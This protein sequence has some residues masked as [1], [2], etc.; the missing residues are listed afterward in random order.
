MSVAI[1]YRDRLVFFSWR[2]AAKGH[3]EAVLFRAWAIW[4][5]IV[6]TS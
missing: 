2:V 4:W 1:E 5:T 6:L 3:P